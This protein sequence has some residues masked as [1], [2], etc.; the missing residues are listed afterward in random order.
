MITSSK[1]EQIKLQQ[2]IQAQVQLQ[3]NKVVYAFMLQIAQTLY[4]A[5]HSSTYHGITPLHSPSEIYI[6]DY[7][8]SPQGTLLYHFSISKSVD[9][10][11]NSTALNCIQK[12]MNADIARYR[13]KIISQHGETYAMANYP[14][15]YHE[16]LVTSIKDIGFN[17]IVTVASRVHP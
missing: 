2:N 12:R 16:I 15:L 5:L 6:E 9:Y 7:T 13:H 3:R 8:L 4:E 1:L 10:P 11:I 14:L 17:V